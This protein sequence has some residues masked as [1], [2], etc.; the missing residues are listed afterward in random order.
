ML[1]IGAVSKEYEVNKSK[2]LS[3]VQYFSLGLSCDYRII[4]GY[5]ANLF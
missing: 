5:E 3:A 4:N 1:S 2:E